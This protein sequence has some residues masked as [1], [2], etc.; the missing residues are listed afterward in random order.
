MKPKQRQT[1]KEILVLWEAGNISKLSLIRRIGGMFA[2][3]EADAYASAR[4]K[5]QAQ[6]PVSG[7]G[8]TQPLV[9]A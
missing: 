1:L 9:A 2:T 4:E 8:C 5:A 3:V 7:G 6:S